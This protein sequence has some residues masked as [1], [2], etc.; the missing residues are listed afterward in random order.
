MIIVSKLSLILLFFKCLPPTASPVLR[1]APG[2]HSSLN[3]SLF[4]LR[5]RQAGLSDGAWNLARLPLPHHLRL[6]GGLGAGVV[7][8]E[9]KVHDARVA[10]PCSLRSKQRECIWK[11]G[12]GRWLLRIITPS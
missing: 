2:H 6:R 12:D 4:A 7:I 8:P 10:G 5:S 3:Q 11:K 9:T 1:P